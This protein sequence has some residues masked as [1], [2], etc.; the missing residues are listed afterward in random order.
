[1]DDNLGD[2]VAIIHRCASCGEVKIQLINDVYPNN[3]YICN[4]DGMAMF[5]RLVRKGINDD[6]N[7]G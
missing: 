2:I 7:T 1:M 4:K 6:F 3:E 5:Q